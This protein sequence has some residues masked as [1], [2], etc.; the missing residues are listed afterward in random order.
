MAEQDHR[1]T[2]NAARRLFEFYTPAVAEL[3]TRFPGVQDDLQT[4]G[5]P[6]WQAR[7]GTLPW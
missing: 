1:H 6:E 5:Y 7:S 4:F 3:V 2:T